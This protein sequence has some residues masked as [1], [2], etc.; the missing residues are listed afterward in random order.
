AFLDWL[1]AGEG[2]DWLD[3]GCGTGALAQAIAEKAT[4]RSLVGIDAS[5]GFVDY[6]KSHVECATASFE[7]GDAQALSLD[8]ARV[9]MAVSG[10]VLNFV[11]QPAQMVAEMRRVTRPGGT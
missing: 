7:V 3:L 11:P 9:D 10:L 8:A 1:D 4:P 2:K 6:A 5:A